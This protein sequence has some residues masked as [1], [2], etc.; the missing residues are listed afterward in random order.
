VRPRA[1]TKNL[2]GAG[3]VIRSPLPASVEAETTRIARELLFPAFAGERSGRRRPDGLSP[4]DLPPFG[5]RSLSTVAAAEGRAGRGVEGASGDA[6][7]GPG[8]PA[9]TQTQNPTT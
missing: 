1:C 8:L 7:K 5:R 6:L 9:Q 4:D 3:V 2:R